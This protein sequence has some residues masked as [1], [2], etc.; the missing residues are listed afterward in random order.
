[1]SSSE[2]R[3]TDRRF[4]LLFKFRRCRHCA[5]LVK[6]T[7]QRQHLLTH[8]PLAGGYPFREVSQAFD[9]TLIDVLE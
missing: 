1:M 6:L 5:E 2:Q 4:E 7:D 9:V 8:D 3:V